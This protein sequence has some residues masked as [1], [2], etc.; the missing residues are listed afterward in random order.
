MRL[1]GFFRRGLG[2]FAAGVVL[3]SPVL[4]ERVVCDVTRI[5]RDLDPSVGETIVIDFDNFTGAAQIDDGFPKPEDL[6]HRG[7]IGRDT[8]RVL[9]FQWDQPGTITRGRITGT[10][11]RLRISIQRGNGQAILSG[12]TGFMSDYV[13]SARARCRFGARASG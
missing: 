7:K 13:L 9:S 6:P 8:S 5:S 11:L 10:G 4:A 2:A 3:A 1:A 12:A